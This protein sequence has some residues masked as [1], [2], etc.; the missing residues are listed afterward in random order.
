MTTPARMRPLHP[1]AHVVADLVQTF[2]LVARGAPIPVGAL[3]TGVSLAS[4]D[5]VAGDVFVA[6]T[7]FQVHGATYAA[8]AV[9][10]GAVAVLTDEAG[11][12]LLED[13]G[14]ARRIPV[15]VTED[16]RA[17]GRASCRERVYS[18]V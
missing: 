10:A 15:L 11:A 17:I 14:L 5:V 13:S 16:P 3:L 9:D 7:G 12:A 2:G 1:A 4:G 18:G 6:V 8:Q